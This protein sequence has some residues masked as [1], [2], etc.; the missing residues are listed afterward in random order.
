MKLLITLVSLSFVLVSC[1]SESESNDYSYT[2]EQNG[3][4]TGTQ[5]FNSLE[6][7]CRGLTDSSLNK[8]CAS[9]LRCRKFVEDNCDQFN[10]DTSCPL[11]SDFE[12]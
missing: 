7:M 1:N 12:I 10:I 2:L 3:C 9:T 4:S 8:G 5:S 11:P 6:A